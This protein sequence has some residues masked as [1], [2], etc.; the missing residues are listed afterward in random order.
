[1]R[2]RLAKYRLCGQ[3][4]KF[5]SSRR[6]LEWPNGAVENV[7]SAEGPDG[8]RGPQFDCAWADEYCAWQYPEKT[9]SNIRLALRLV[10][11]TRGKRTRAEPV[12]M[13]YEQG[14]VK[15]EGK[16]F[17]KLEDELIQLGSFGG[18]RDSPDALVLG[19]H[20]VIVEGRAAV[21]DTGFVAT[22]ID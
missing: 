1:M 15:H 8:L 10:T 7:F 5:T 4:P 18:Y 17:E 9:L 16:G 14:R 12:Y 3:R 20:G 11:T 2:E 22:A 13:L 21:P 6:L 19:G